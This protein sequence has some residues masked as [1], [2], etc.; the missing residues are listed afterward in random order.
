MPKLRHFAG[1]NRAEKALFLR[2]LL[3]LPLVDAELRVRGWQRC[4]TRLVKWAK[5]CRLSSATPG[6]LPERVAWLVE[7]AARNVPWPATCLRRSLVLWALLERAGIATELRL[8]FRKTDGVFEA[9]AW[10]E[11]NGVPLNDRRDVR[12]RYQMAAQALTPGEWAEA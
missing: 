3:M 7:C 8:G 12:T 10:V 1:L 9:H 11:L 4:H 5:R 6:I 2:A